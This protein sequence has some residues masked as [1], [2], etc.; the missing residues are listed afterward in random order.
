MVLQDGLKSK[1][2][3]P[4]MVIGFSLAVKGS[5]LGTKDSRDPLL[6]ITS[7]N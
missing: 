2:L 7:I 4:S 5:L 1:V 3:F 6:N